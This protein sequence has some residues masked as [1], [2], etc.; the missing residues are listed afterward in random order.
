MSQGVFNNFQEILRKYT[1]NTQP[2]IHLCSQATVL[3]DGST[4]A[5]L[6]CSVTSD[7]RYTIRSQIK[8]CLEIVYTS[9]S[10]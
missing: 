6:S 1:G 3:G 9:P 2:D 7:I 10:V 5:A 4:K 8:C